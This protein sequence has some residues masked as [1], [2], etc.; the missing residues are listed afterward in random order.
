MRASIC[1]KNCEVK[2]REIILIDGKVWQET[3]TEDDDI[4]QMTATEEKGKETEESE[5]TVNP[6]F[7]NTET[8][9][10]RPK[11][12]AA[13]KQKLL[14]EKL[15]ESE[16]LQVASKPVFKPRN[17]CKVPTHGFNYDYWLKLLEDT[18]DNLE[19]V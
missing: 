6:E 9:I 15:L 11:Y 7:D 12:K 17:K 16:S 3:S 19:I 1:L 2:L 4:E 5:V 8:H 13:L 18:E 14:M 10:I